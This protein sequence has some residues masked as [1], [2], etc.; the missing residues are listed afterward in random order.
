MDTRPPNDQPDWEA[1]RNQW[2]FPSEI[3]YL[4][5]GSFGSSPRP[6]REAHRRWQDRLQRE[7][8]DF[9]IRE[10]EGHLA[11]TTG[12]LGEFVGARPDDLVLMDNATYAMNVVAASFELTAGDEVLLTDHEYGAVARLWEKTCEK[13]DARVTRAVLPT[14]FQSADEV[15]DAIVRATT[16]RTRLLVFSH[17]TSPTAVVLPAA[18]ICAA[19][20]ARG[21]VVCIDGPHAVAMRPL[22]LAA[23]DCDYYTASCHKWLSAP[24]GTGF[25]YAHPR[26]QQ[27]VVPAIT[28]WG[29]LLPDRP[30]SWRDEFTWIGTRDPTPLLCISAAIEFLREVG[31][32][33][34]RRRTHQLARYARERI[35]SLTG[36]QPMTADD[37][38]WYGSMIALPLPPRESA[39][40]Q[41][42]L[43][44]RH[45][46]EVPIVDWQDGRQV[47]VSCHVHTT[48]AD[49]DRVVAALDELL[50]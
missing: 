9:F 25:L 13:A 4:N 43:R 20:R 10:L 48:K 36:L 50:G 27:G 6:V 30:E 2:D 42:A 44:E 24:F 32:D 28:S 7:P 12:I 33:A 46:V 3:T 8:M 40:L 47:R 23:L 34:F 14:V 21:V 22:D 49:V 26:V 17:I 29:R 39:P 31:L 15:V 11:D 5:H 16:D 41:L 18:E 45:G 38:A 1:L 35:V 19:M 37:P